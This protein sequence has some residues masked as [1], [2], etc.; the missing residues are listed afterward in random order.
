MKSN[1]CSHEHILTLVTLQT[2]GPVVPEDVAT[3]LAYG[4][5]YPWA[6][7]RA[8]TPPAVGYQNLFPDMSQG[9]N[10]YPIR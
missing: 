9:C 5:C 2:I 7:S 10:I 6:T 4:L 1:S 3:L 8:W